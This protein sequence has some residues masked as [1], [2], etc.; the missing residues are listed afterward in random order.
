MKKLFIYLSV[1]VLG[2]AAASC[3]KELAVAEGGKGNVNITIQTPEVATKA[4]A[5]GMN[6]NI[7]HYEI[8]KKEAGHKNSLT[9]KPLIKNTV[10]MTAKGASLTLNLLQGQEYVGLFWAQVDGKS[11]YTTTDL[12]NVTVNY[13]GSA[14]NENRAAFCQKKVF[15]TGGNVSVVLERPFAQ[16]N[17]GTTLSSIDSEVNGY[18]LVLESSTMEIVGAATS[19]SVADMKTGTATTTV[20]FEANTVPHNFTPSEVLTVNN[21]PY[22][23]LGMNYILAANDKATVDVKYTVSTDVGSI[24]RTIPTVPVEKNHR[25]NL[26]GN[27][28]TQETAIEIVV[29]ERFVE[30]DLEPAPI[31]MAAAMGGEYTLT[32]DLVLEAPV[33]VPAN[34]NFVLNLNGKSIKNKTQ[35]E[36]FGE[37]EGIIAYGNLTINGEGT[38]EGSTMA[39]W[40]RGADGAY[41]TINGGTYKGCAEGYAKGGRSVI[42]A[43]SGNTI[44][45]YGGTFQSLTADKASYADKTNGVYAALNVADNN[46]M[47]NVYGGTFVKQNP[48]AP[49]TEPA[50]WNAAHPN[51]FVAEGYKAVEKDGV[52]HVV[53]AETTAVV[54]TADEFKAALAAA[55]EADNTTVVIDANGAEFDMNGAITKDNVP[56]GTTVTIRNANV[57]ARSYGNKLEGTVVYENCTFNNAAGAY[58][59][60]FDGGNGHVIFKNCDLYGWNS[61]GY[62]GSVTL[63]NCTLNGNG[64]YALIRSYTAMTLTNCTINLSNANHDDEWP[65][66]VEAIEGGTLTET[67]VVYVVDDVTTLQY[68]LN[69]VDKSTNI[70]FGQDL[71]GNVTLVQKPNVN[72]D[73]NGDN[74]KYDGQISIEGGI[75]GN[76]TETVK[77]H[78]VNFEHNTG[79]IDF[80]FGDD[81]ANIKRYAHNVT[82]ENCSFAGTTG[83]VIGLRFRQAYNLVVRK[84]TANGIHSLAQ[85]SSTSPQLYE[86]CDINAGRGLNLLT[87]SANTVVKNCKIVSTKEDGYG[88]RV[89]A[90]AGNMMTVTGCEITAFEPIVL[91]NAASTYTLNLE[92]TALT[93]RSGN[94]IV[95]KGQEP[96]MNGVDGL[97]VKVN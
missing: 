69:Q 18:D 87:S 93:S 61:F 57:N 14:N 63:E 6:V 94:D 51:G 49:G 26:I 82:V 90:A 62:I 60:H 84:C 7:V 59:I 19:F 64:T 27:L 11:F 1:A 31:Y 85:I 75:Q 2:I 56:A 44:D 92:N 68:V 83:D 28:L 91:R 35:S 80:I 17:L 55:A 12:R 72:I 86:D 67:N 52:W 21:V 45:I 8:Y 70:K 41:V 73:I 95:V 88:I 9:G 39:V 22:S 5:D 77:I 66:G 81:A 76:S 58:S 25:T 74:Y 38:V 48:A 42:Y 10:R 65:E 54:L 46:G 3:Q 79:S 20:S 43:S 15:T 30:P 23:Y 71:E 32:E 47:I 53:A 36:V 29:D 97:T 13:T 96:A 37:G 4:I 89:D 34:T 16:I 40:A 78:H 33:V 24:T 50:A